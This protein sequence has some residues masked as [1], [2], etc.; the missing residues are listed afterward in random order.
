M[1]YMNMFKTY[2]LVK[3]YFHKDT[4]YILKIILCLEKVI[5]N[6]W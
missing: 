2:I 4:K 6:I 3:K 5:I 1:T